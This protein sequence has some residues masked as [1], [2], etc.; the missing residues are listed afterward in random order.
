MLDKGDEGLLVRAEPLGWAEEVCKRMVAVERTV[1]RAL[2]LEADP[3]WAGA[4]NAVLVN[5]GATVTELRGV[6]VIRS[7]TRRPYPTPITL[8][9]STPRSFH[10]SKD[11][12]AKGVN[13]C[14]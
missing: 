8:R 6:R 5:K 1:D 2:F 14:G 3:S 13:S 7:D 12:L 11:E 4:I 10:G 9:P